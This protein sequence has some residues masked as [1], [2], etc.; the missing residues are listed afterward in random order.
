MGV[1]LMV[2]SIYLYFVR[3]VDHAVFVLT[4]AGA[5]LFILGLNL[6]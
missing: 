4:G 2:I 5:V 6:K 3:G 1:I